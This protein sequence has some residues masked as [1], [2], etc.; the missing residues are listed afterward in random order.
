MIGH[1]DDLIRKRSFVRVA[2]YDGDSPFVRKNVLQSYPSVAVGS[3]VGGKQ[4]SNLS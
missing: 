1:L 4:D 3:I 2:D